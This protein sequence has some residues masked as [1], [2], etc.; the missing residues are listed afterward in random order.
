M[1]R[2]VFLWDAFLGG[3]KTS[4]T[5]RVIGRLGCL[6]AIAATLHWPQRGDGFQWFQDP[7]F[8]PNFKA[9]NEICL[10]ANAQ[11]R[12]QRF[13]EAPSG[14]L[15]RESPG[16]AS[17]ALILIPNGT[18]VKIIQCETK[19]ETIEGI[20]GN[21]CKVTF[22]I[23]Y[24]EVFGEF[25]DDGRKADSVSP[26][27]GVIGMCKVEFADMTGWLFDGYLRGCPIPGRGN[28]VCFDEYNKV[29]SCDR[30]RTQCIDGC[31]RA[32]RFMLS[33]SASNRCSEEC[34]MVAE[35]CA[36]QRIVDLKGFAK[37]TPTCMD[38]FEVCRTRCPFDRSSG[39]RDCVDQCEQIKVNCWHIE[40]NLD[41]KK[42]ARLKQE[43]VVCL[44]SERYAFAEPDAKAPIYMITAMT[45][46][47]PLFI[48]NW[49]AGVYSDAKM[50]F[51]TKW[52]E[53]RLVDNT[54]PKAFVLLSDVDS[55]PTGK[56]RSWVE[57]FKWKHKEAFRVRLNV[58]GRPAP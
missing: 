13:V 12:E 45:A 5:G 48:L 14:L 25:C 52:L 40:M 22:P 15:L 2:I 50:S 43:P 16:R 31:D 46:F 44:R 55:C 58:T 57:D 26:D 7:R 54:G 32:G 39:L 27:G 51:K 21:W 24:R 28:R 47:A 10:G 20:S 33:G 29:M 8:Y 35:S 30:A 23:K 53:G 19:P 11:E 1:Q 56:E 34:S 18:R 38:Q 17:K 36:A 9:C 41:E 37:E 3:N 4:C 6:M 49:D 42:I